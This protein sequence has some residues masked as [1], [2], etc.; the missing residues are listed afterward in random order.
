LHALVDEVH[1][2]D[3]RSAVK[4]VVGKRT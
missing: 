4:I 3:E 1:L 2:L